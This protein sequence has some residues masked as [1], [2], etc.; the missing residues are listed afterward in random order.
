MEQQQRIERIT[1]CLSTHKYQDTPQPERMSALVGIVVDAFGR[2]GQGAGGAESLASRLDREISD[3]MG[4]QLTLQEALL[5]IDWGLHGEYGEYTGLNTERLFRF[6]R[7]YL[8]SQ[9]RQEAIRLWNRGRMQPGDQ[10]PTRDQVNTRNWEAMYSEF[11]G[12]VDAWRRTGTVEAVRRVIPRVHSSGEP[13][14]LFSEEGLM[15][16]R[17]ECTGMCYLWLKRLGYV[18]Y[19][20][21]TLGSEIEARKRAEAQLR[22]ERSVIARSTVDSLAYSMMMLVFFRAQEASGTDLDAVLAEIGQTPE[23][24]RR[25]WV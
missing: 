24:E 20:E 21:T 4:R 17:R 19:D 6:V 8:E 14:P 23:I 13:R 22:Q 10:S 5:A 7:A 12:L 3:Y 25:F 9:D 2:K 18:L 16:A 15:H 11:T 1:Q